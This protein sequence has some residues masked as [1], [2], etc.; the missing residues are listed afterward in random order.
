MTKKKEKALR[1]R[2]LEII[3]ALSDM[4]KDWSRWTSDDWQPLEKELRD[5]T[6]PNPFKE[7]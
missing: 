2:R 6:L 4:S 1:K 7:V 5:L 3:N